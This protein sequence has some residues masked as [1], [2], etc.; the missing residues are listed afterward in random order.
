MCDIWSVKFSET[1]VVPV[2]NSVA[3]KWGVETV[4]D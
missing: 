2:L 4:T 3:R 1:V